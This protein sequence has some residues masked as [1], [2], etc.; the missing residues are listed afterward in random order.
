MTNEGAI[1]TLKDLKSYYND[2]S[3][4]S[5]IGFDDKDNEAIDKAIDVLEQTEWIPVTERL[6]EPQKDGNKDFSEWVLITLYIGENDYVVGR[7]YYCFSDKTWY[8]ERFGC[9][10]VVAW[11]P[12]PEPYKKESEE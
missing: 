11:M 7:A 10:K 3:Q 12:Q 8:A 6:P 1:N 2:K 9:G 5:Y 4:D